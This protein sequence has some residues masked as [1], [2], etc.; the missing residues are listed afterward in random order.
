[1]TLKIFW[2]KAWGHWVG[3]EEVSSFLLSLWSLTETAIP[4]LDHSY[5]PPP[6]FSQHK[7]SLS[8]DLE[9]AVWPFHLF[10]FSS[11]LPYNLTQSTSVWQIC[12]FHHQYQRKYNRLC[13][14]ICFTLHSSIQLSIHPSSIYLHMYVCTMYVYNI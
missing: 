14:P 5:H 13:S 9:C 2:S 6:T 10:N 8:K 7:L 3:K 4:T 12:S 1:M 11:Q